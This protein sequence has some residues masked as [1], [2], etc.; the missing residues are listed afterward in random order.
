MGRAAQRLAAIVAGAPPTPEPRIGQQQQSAGARTSALNER[1]ARG[2]GDGFG[3]ACELSGMQ[4]PSASW[5][6]PQAGGDRE[7]LVAQ[8]VARNAQM[9]AAIAREAAAH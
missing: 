4:Q 9:V 3:G 1:A 6:P 2:D 5:A 8:M 7:A